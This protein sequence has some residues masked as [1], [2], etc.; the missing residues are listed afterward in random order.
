MAGK[1]RG[2]DWLMQSAINKEN[3]YYD[4]F[5]LPLVYKPGYP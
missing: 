3:W 4:L 5:L 2:N 1:L